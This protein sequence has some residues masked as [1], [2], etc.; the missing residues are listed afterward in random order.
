MKSY[1]YFQAISTWHVWHLT[2][3]RFIFN[4][5]LFV[6]NKINYK[7]RPLQTSDINYR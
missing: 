4:T 3:T 5:S 2:A 1:L 7:A 6:D